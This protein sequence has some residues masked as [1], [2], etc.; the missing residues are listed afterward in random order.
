M[1]EKLDPKTHIFAGARQRVS[2]LP[3]VTSLE[4]MCREATDILGAGLRN[5][6]IIFEGRTANFFAEKNSMERAATAVLDHVLKNPLFFHELSREHSAH[7]PALISHAKMAHRLVQETHIAD[8][9][10][11]ALYDGFE[12]YYRMMYA[13]YAPVWLINDTLPAHLFSLVSSRIPDAAEAAE[14]LD[15]LTREP[16]A[17]LNSVEHRAL[18]VLAA[19]IQKNDDWVKKILGGKS[20][21]SAALEDKIRT[22]LDSFF[23]L[24]R[25]YED[26]VLTYGDVEKKLAEALTQSPC[27]ELSQIEKKE[28]NF[29]KRSKEILSIY[30]FNSAEISLFEA[31]KEATHLKELRKR[32]VS[33]ALYFFDAIL[34]EIGRRLFLSIAQVRFMNSDDAK[35]ALLE[36]EDLTDELNERMK[37]SVWYSRDGKETEIITGADAEGLRNLFLRVDMD[38][39]EI[40]GTPVSSGKARGRARIVMNPDECAR[41]EKGDILVTVQVVP[42]F[43]PAISRAAAIVC[44]G[45]TGMTSHPAT[46]AREAGIPC[47]I[48]ARFATQILKDGDVVEVDGYSGVV[49]KLDSACA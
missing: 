6:F 1:R 26:P 30:K 9:E 35:R 21:D 8:A 40:A 38:A 36:G 44:E 10:L 23:W 28:Q 12:K 13:P 48:Q 34:S 45:G 25:D 49:K 5:T 39:R 20:R 27:E 37:L 7:A 19:E 22:H 2:P 31:M 4:I 3:N 32:H 41:V 33:E 16:R 15:I 42:N 46:L 18:I 14:A 24:T 11:C 29:E 17:M 47:V 43:S